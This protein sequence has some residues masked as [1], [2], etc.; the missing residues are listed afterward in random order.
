MLRRFIPAVFV[1]V[2]V[3]ACATITAQTGSGEGGGGTEGISIEKMARFSEPGPEHD[4]L[5]KFR[6]RWTKRLE[7]RPEPNAE[8]QTTELE[9][10]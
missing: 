5:D 3:G 4:L 6:G 10:E 9:T 8:T 7:F 1:L 2:L